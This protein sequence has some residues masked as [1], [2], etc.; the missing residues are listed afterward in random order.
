MA[1]NLMTTRGPWQHTARTMRTFADPLMSFAIQLTALPVSTPLPVGVVLA[2]AKEPE[3]DA[4]CIERRY[5]DQRR[6]AAE[7]VTEAQSLIA[8]INEKLDK[9]RRSLYEYGD[10]PFADLERDAR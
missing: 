3:C 6:E 5:R 8:A 9:A 10:V 4:A 7:A 2:E 1:R